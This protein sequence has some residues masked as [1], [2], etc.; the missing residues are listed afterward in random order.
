MADVEQL[1]ARLTLDMRQF[2]SEMLKAQGVSAKA[3]RDTERAWAATNGKL[4][5]IGKSM[6]SGLIAPLAAVGAAASTREVIAYADAWTTAKNK[7]AAA[8]QSS[9]RQARSLEELNALA[10]ETRS[11]IGETVDLYAKLLRS[12][13]KVAKSEEEVARATEIVNK[14]FKAGGAGASEQAAGI[15]QLSQA[16]GSGVLQGDELRSLRENAP[17]LAQAIADEFGTTIAGLKKLGAEGE[18]TSERVFQAIL[19]AQ[20]KIQ[21]M[22]GATNQT[23]AEGV[24]KVNNAF[25]QYIGSTDSSL[26]ASQRLVGGLNALADNFDGI[27]DATIKVAAIIAGAL[28]GRSIVLMIAKLGLAASAMMRF[29][30][31]LKAAQGIAAVST[32]IGGIGAAAGPVGLAV[33]TVLTGALIAFGAQ[34]GEASDAADAYAAE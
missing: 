12:T 17:L 7:L 20:P 34:S 28:V 27:A 32:A 11:G 22:F 4:N 3:A 30:A 25:T 8:G 18:L 13:A 6:A 26:D 23:I 15:L 10:N 24:T 5:S 2:R 9:G 1:V 21:A 29:V 14:A 19:K 33:G 31:A 16:L